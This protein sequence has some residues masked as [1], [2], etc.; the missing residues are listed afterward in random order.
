MGD[1][2][3]GLGSAEDDDDADDGFEG[4]DELKELES[5]PSLRK[6]IEEVKQKKEEEAAEALRAKASIK[7][8]AK[9][10]KD[11][12]LR[13]MRKILSATEGEFEDPF[14]HMEDSITTKIEDSGSQF[15]LSSAER[16]D[17]VML[18]DE[19]A[20]KKKPKINKSSPLQSLAQSQQENMLSD[21][22][23]DS[24]WNEVTF[25]RAPDTDF[26]LVPLKVR[27]KQ[28]TRRA[29]LLF[30][31]LL[32][33]GV[34]P[35][36]KILNEMFAVY[37]EAGNV[38]MALDI[39]TKYPQF[40]CPMTERTYRYKIMMYI[41]MKDIEAAV[42]VKE[43][44]K[45]NQIIPHSDSYGYIIESYVHRNMLVEALQTLEEA[46]SYNVSLAE[47]HLRQLRT[48]CEKLKIVHPDVPPD[49]L[50][51]A[52]ESKA[53]RRRHRDSPQS[54]I[55]QINSRSYV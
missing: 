37:S 26:H 5:D 12:E 2:F 11:A 3:G 54:T 36:T 16:S 53:N 1:Q 48:R 18:L 25:G 52:K 43:E 29:E 45:Q 39:L 35:N 55:E 21:S 40:N 47:K 4:L 23:I 28:N 7:K 49:P 51:W 13:I 24:K 38:E 6:L 46:K 22:Y 42:Q 34:K 20:N 19:V 10:G 32:K 50:K 31:H 14:A 27:R 17:L 8:E 9:P 30:D 33:E 44:M 15:K 41:R